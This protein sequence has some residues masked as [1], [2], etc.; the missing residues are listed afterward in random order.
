VSPPSLTNTFFD[1][2][3]ELGWIEGKNISVEYRY[4]EDQPDRLA[5]FAADLVRL[6]VDVIVAIATLGPLAAKR[7]TLR[8]IRL[9]GI[10]GAWSSLARFAPALVDHPLGLPNARSPYGGGW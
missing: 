6:K 3:R 5:E 2:L 8:G 10:A 7:A 4:A 1:K 9:S